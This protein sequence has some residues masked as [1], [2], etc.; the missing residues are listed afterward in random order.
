MQNLKPLVFVAEDDSRNLRILE[1]VL[2]G[3]GCKVKS[4][5]DGNLVIPTVESISPDLIILDINLPHIDG[6]TLCREIRNKENML[7]IPIILITS[8]YIDDDSLI[9]GLDIGAIEYIKRPI[10]PEELSARIRAGLRIREF[11]KKLKQMNEELQIAKDRYMELAENLDKK[12]KEQTL[13]ILESEKKY[14]NLIEQAKYGILLI[15]P[16]T[17]KIIEVNPFVEQ[18]LEMKENEIVNKSFIEFFQNEVKNRV[19]AGLRLAKIKGSRN[20]YNVNLI[21]KDGTNILVDLSI[22]NL[23]INGKEIF[24]VSVYDLR[25]REKLEIELRKSE[26][27]TVIGSLTAGIIHEIN[28]PLTAIVSLAQSIADD[29]KDNSSLKND[30]KLI[31]Q[32]ALRASNVLN[33]L[34]DYVKLKPKNIGCVSIGEVL[35]SVYILLKPQLKKQKVEFIVK[36][37]KEILVDG[38]F[39]QLKQ[40]FVNIIIN[41]IQAMPEGGKIEVYAEECVIDR[42]KGWQIDV[43]DTGKGFAEEDLKHLFEPFY[44]R[45]KQQGT[46]LGLSISQKIIEEHKGKITAFNNKYGGAQIRIFLRKCVHK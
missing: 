12:V 5:M 46:G 27:L 6:F 7:D 21:R 25:E 15:E 24:L 11:Q 44:T 31:E 28:N 2:K 8:A 20:F 32:E 39:S 23:K 4:V 14:R 37:P 9:K 33:S 34:L 17:E 42:K 40:V 19:R 10:F 18:M 36:I 30:I 1:K 41:S 26:R 16:K 38:D 3:I 22:V 13:Y 43:L 35:D 45:G 29:L